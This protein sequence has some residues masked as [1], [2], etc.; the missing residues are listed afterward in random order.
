MRDQEIGHLAL[1]ST[2]GL[3]TAEHE[4]YF[5]VALTAVSKIETLT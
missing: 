4:P 2:D 3:G 1:A 5:W